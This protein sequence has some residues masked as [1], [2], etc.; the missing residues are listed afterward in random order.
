M[1]TSREIIPQYQY[2]YERPSAQAFGIGQCQVNGIEYYSNGLYWLGGVSILGQGAA[3]WIVPALAAADA[4]TY[5]KSGTTLTVTS[6]GHLMTAAVNN[7][8]NVYLGLSGGTETTGW[9]SNFTYVDANTFTCTS[10]TSST[11]SGTVLTNA[12]AAKLLPVSITVPANTM[13]TNGR[14]R[15]SYVAAHNNSAGTK[16][17]RIRF[18]S[19]DASLVTTTTTL[20]VG[21]CKNIANRNATNKQVME[22]AYSTGT[23]TNAAAPT[24]LTVDTTADV[25]I[26]F[27]IQLNTANDWQ[28]IESYMIE[29]I[30]G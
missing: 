28:Q 15:V 11:D 26:T 27:S 13:G 7:N 5:T 22:M 16:I 4:A 21:V 2:L 20:S 17:S 29:V 1:P 14:V 10:S 3:G 6:T 25:A 24:N 30:P 23:G 18:G 9:F 19:S 8:R 12:S